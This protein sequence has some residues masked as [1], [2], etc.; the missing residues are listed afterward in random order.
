M[1]Y[2]HTPALDFGETAVCKPLVPQA[3]EAGIFLPDEAHRRDTFPESFDDFCHFDTSATFIMVLMQTSFN[4]PQ[5]FAGVLS[6]GDGLSGDRR[7]RP[8]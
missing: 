5:A 8:P 7:P 6:A 1:P 2:P 3:A 4:H